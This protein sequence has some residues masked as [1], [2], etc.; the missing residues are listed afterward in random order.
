MSDGVSVTRGSSPG[1]A[2]DLLIL[3]VLPLVVG[4]AWFVD[5]PFTATLATR[6]AVLG[7]AGIGL[8]LALGSGGLVSFGHAA[9][10]GI[11][12]YALA[13][14]ASHVQD[15]APLALGPFG[16][17]GSD[18]MPV[19]WLV[20][21]C[22]GALA[23]WLIGVLSLR[24]SGAYFILITLAFGQMLYLFA[25]AWPAYG[26]EDGLVLYTR[27]TLGA[28]RTM[29]PFVYFGIVY[30]LLCAVLAGVAAILRSAFGL[31]LEAV[32]EAP[33]RVESLGIEPD[34]VRL[35]AFV[36]SGAITALAGALFAD[37][38]RFASPA[39][40]GWQTS[41]EIMVFVILGGT[42]RLAGPLVGAGLFVLLEHVL[43][44][45]SEHWHLALGA[46]L[47][48]TVLF[49]GGGVL[50]ALDRVRAVRPRSDG[51]RTDGARTD[52]ARS[53]HG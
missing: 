29:D 22:A 51:A 21:V 4:H 34:R 12:G 52:G 43:G 39:M 37:L 30:A 26:G 33:A 53:R 40:L 10:F 44:G 49:A 13:I 17:A 18:S 16:F 8:N 36:I 42:G 47:L 15:G 32:R 7:L 38:N 31:A 3:S 45:T 9:F 1:R 23:A 25:V 27:N 24:T 28:L 50:G 5:E 41:G 46:I 2:L 48:A 35:V 6:A 14:L 20:A 11:G 19:A